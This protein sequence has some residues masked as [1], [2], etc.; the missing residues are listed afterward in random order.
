VNRVGIAW[1][2]GKPIMGLPTALVTR[3]R[4]YGRD[5]VP[6]TGGIVVA[7]VLLGVAGARWW[8][9]SQLRL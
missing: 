2:I 9:H 5:R 8:L 4:I 7:Y 6:R 3:L 1:A